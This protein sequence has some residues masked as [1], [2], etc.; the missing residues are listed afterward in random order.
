MCATKPKGFAFR[1]KTRNLL[2]C[3]KT[4]GERLTYTKYDG[5]S[6]LDIN[7]ELID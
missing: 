3:T 7:E 1:V 5:A 4:D 6:V 2:R